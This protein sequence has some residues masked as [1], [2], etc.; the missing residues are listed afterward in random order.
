MG[1]VTASIRDCSGGF[2]RSPEQQNLNADTQK[3]MKQ[4]CRSAFDLGIAAS[5]RQSSIVHSEEFKRERV[6]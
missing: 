4:F 5:H 1:S 3:C 6:E 2:T